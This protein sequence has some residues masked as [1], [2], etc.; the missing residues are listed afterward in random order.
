MPITYVPQQNVQ[1]IKGADGVPVE[2][3]VEDLQPDEYWSSWDALNPFAEEG[4][5]L[6]HVEDAADTVKGAGAVFKKGRS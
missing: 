5:V 2:V 4:T 6:F 3:T 1:S